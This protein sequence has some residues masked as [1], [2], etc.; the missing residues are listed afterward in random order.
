MAGIADFL[1][2]GIELAMFPGSRGLHFYQLFSF[3]FKVPGPDDTDGFPFYRFVVE[4]FQPILIELNLFCAGDNI[5]DWLPNFNLGA[6]LFYR[7]FGIATSAGSKKE[8]AQ[9]KYNYDQSFSCGELKT[10]ERFKSFVW[11]HE[12]EYL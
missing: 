7:K 6:E 4:F 3:L 9:Y 5:H 11:I 12:S 1:N 10:V 8:H 2:H